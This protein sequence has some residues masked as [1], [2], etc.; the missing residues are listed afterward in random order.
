MFDKIIVAVLINSS[1][2]PL[3][4]VE[5]RTEM[6]RE[7]T[8]HLSNVEVDSFNGLLVDYLKK[9]IPMPS[10]AAFGRF[11]ILSMNCRLPP[12]TEN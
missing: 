3:F 10:Y 9:E 8:R 11:P 6:I 12:S 2:D 1:K 7:A 5:E 4:S